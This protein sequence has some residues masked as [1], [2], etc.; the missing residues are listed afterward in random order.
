MAKLEHDIKT[1]AKSI[2]QGN[3][4]RKKRIKANIASTFDNMAVD[5]VEDALQQSCSNI[6]CEEPRKQMQE[7]IY[8]SIVYNTPYEYIGAM[9]G[10]RQFYDYRTEFITLVADRMGM[11]PTA[12]K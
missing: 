6:S 4:Q 12:N 11:L 5:I 10:R 7:Q 1:I 2:I 3:E 8:Q 9:C